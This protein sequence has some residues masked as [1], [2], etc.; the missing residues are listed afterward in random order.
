MVTSVP[1]KIY[2]PL[3]SAVGHLMVNWTFLDSELTFWC[4]VIYHAAGG[5]AKEPELPGNYRR[6]A[7]FLCRC[8]RQIGSLAPFKDE[9]LPILNTASRLSRTR[10]FIAHGTISA[11]D[12]TADHLLTCVKIDR[13]EDY[14]KHEANELKITLTDLLKTGSDCG[15]LAAE[16]G[17]MCKRLIKTFMA[18]DEADEFL[19]RV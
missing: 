12:E 18:K 5:K 14:T 16:A 4:A 17:N 19:G 10:N 7:Q 9:A 6:K 15:T 11:Y 8:F 2:E 1:G 3:C 13:D